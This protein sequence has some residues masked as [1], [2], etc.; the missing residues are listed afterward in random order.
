MN[1]GE[2]IIKGIPVKANR[3]DSGDVNL[4][5]KIGTYDEKESVCRVIVKKDYWKNASTGMKDVNYFVI[6]GKLK[7][8]VN[9][10]GVPFIAVEASSIKIFNLPKDKDGEI[11][12]NYELPTGT[13]EIIDISRIVN[14]NED[15]SVKRAKNKAISYM[16]NNNKFNKP[17]TVRKETMVMVSGQDQYAAAK[18]LGISNVP[19]TYV[20]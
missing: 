15:L 1:Q 13:D 5:F 19:V 16:K 3:L 20:D 7:A 11:D 6:K 10:K 9:S 4:L 2:I 17:I 14:D 8:C 18:E 12:L